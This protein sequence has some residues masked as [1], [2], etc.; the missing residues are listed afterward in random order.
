MLEQDRFHF[1]RRDG[2]P[3]VLDHF[4]HAIDDAVET[5]AVDAGH[6]ARPIP[7]IAK[8]RVRSVGG[9]P[10]TEHNLRPT[11]DQLAGE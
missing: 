2:K 5:I 9:I 3:L 10:I 4:L 8:H 11:H 1:R 6:I 7:A